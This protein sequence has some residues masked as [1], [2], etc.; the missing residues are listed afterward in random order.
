M[1]LVRSTTKKSLSI[2]EKKHRAK[3]DFLEDTFINKNKVWTYLISNQALMF[4]LH[5]LS[6]SDCVNFLNFFFENKVLILIGL[7]GCPITNFPITW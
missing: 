1:P 6:T 3:Y 2:T 4:D 7:S 5:F